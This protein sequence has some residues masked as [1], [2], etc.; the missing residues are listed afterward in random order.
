[1]LV[2]GKHLGETWLTGPFSAP[3][4]S[5]GTDR[6]Q[7]ERGFSLFAWRCLFCFLPTEVRYLLY[8]EL[9]SVYLSAENIKFR[10]ALQRITPSASL[11]TVIRENNDVAVALSIDSLNRIAK[12]ENSYMTFYVHEQRL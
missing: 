11:R 1:M 12:V 5:F 7:T 8:P 2:N 4:Q 6:N 9:Y 3:P 10:F